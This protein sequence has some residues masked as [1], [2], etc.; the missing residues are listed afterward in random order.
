MS[1]IV[2]YHFSLVSPYSY[3][4]HE[5][6]GKIASAAGAE[7]NYY[8]VSLAKI[9]PATGG[10][11]LPKRAPE[12]QAYR[13]LE[14]ARWRDHLGLPLNLEPKHFPAPEADAAHLVIAARGQ[15]IDVAPL[16]GAILG[17]VWA[18][19][20]NIG[21][22]ETVRAIADGLGLDGAG[23]MAA[24]DDPAVEAED[25]GG[26]DRAI[27]RGVF[28]APTYIYDGELFWGQDRLDFL[29][30]ALERG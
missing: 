22:R 25:Q 6:F 13:M 24:A 4:G 20:R 18:E 15:G 17:A 10:L 29:E 11:P 26:T 1:K 8:P 9:F 19:E 7:V 27:E 23:L 12:R 3:M 30:R 16:V 21:D 14:L 5:R 2:D 28:G